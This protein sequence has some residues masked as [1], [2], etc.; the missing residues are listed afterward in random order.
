MRALS[1]RREIVEALKS[2]HEDGVEYW[3]QFETTTFFAVMGSH[4]SP[5]EHVRHLTRSMSPLLSVLR[6]PRVALRMAFGPATTPSRSFEQ[7]AGC[8]GQALARGGT[9]GRYT[10]SPEHESGD[11][12][13][14]NA[15]MDHHS[16][17]L[18]GVTQGM[19]RWTETQLDAHRLPHPLMGKLTVREMMLF[20]LLHNRHHVQVAERRLQETGARR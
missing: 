7:I 3:S 20:T 19:E 13:R 17:T 11:D 12:A 10:P 14:R 2:T 8:Y 15:I 6:V 9:A 1:N 4:W 16:E 5:A 18:R